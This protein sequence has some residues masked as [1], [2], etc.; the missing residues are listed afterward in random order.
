MD[1]AGSGGVG[2][3]EKPNY[4]SFFRGKHIKI[5]VVGGRCDCEEDVQN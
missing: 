2:R 4:G 3:M 5:R 1:N